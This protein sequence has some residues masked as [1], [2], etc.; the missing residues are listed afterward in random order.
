MARLARESW[1]RRQLRVWKRDGHKCL[2]CGWT[3]PLQGLST[4]YG[5][6]FLTVDHV[7]PVSQGGSNDLSN[8]QTLCRR[9]HDKKDLTS[10]IETVNTKHLRFA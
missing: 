9:C 7:V 1:R 4:N 3:N 2:W 5:G 8:L 6:N 10:V